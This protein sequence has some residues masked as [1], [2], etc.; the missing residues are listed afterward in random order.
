MGNI[1]VEAVS[2]QSIPAEEVPTI[3]HGLLGHHLLRLLL[4]DTLREDC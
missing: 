4:Q 1:A 3:F 2:E